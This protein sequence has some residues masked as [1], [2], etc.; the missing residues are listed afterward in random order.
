M[1]AYNST[2]FFQPQWAMDLRTTFL[3]V[4]LYPGNDT[5]RPIKEGDLTGLN[6]LNE[7]FYLVESFV[8]SDEKNYTDLCAKNSY[9][10]KDKCVRLNLTEPFKEEYNSDSKSLLNAMITKPRRGPAYSVDYPAHKVR[11]NISSIRNFKKESQR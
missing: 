7:F 5:M 11:Y 3:S 10:D 2:S 9:F 4:I 6:A 8:S 1:F